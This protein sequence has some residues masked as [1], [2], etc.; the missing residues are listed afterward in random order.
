MSGLKPYLNQNFESIKQSC[1]STGALFVDPEFP[2]S[3]SSLA[4]KNG[5]KNLDKIT[6][7]R[8]KDFVRDPQ[9]IVDKVTPQDLDQG[10]IGDCWIISAM[11]GLATHQEYVD[12]VIPN[13][14]SFEDG[15]YVGMFH[16]RFWQYGEWVDVVIDDLLPVYADDNTLVYCHNNKDH[17]EM[18]G[19]LLEKAFAKLATCY[20]YLIGGN[21]NDAMID[22][23]GGCHETFD[24][25]LSDG[26]DNDGKNNVDHET[27]W[28]V[29]FS[30]HKMGS[31]MASA[32]DVME[33]ADMESEL[34]NGLVMGHAYCVLSV[35]EILS[36]GG[37]YDTLREDLNSNKNERDSIRLVKMRNPWGQKKSFTGP[38][39][40]GK[41]DWRQVSDNI[42]HKLSVDEQL[43]GEFYMNYND[44][45]V[46]FSDI[47]FVHVNMNA[48]YDSTS[49]D[50][51][52]YKWHET[53]FQGQWIP[54]KNAGGKFC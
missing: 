2:A 32:I 49:H 15:D 51:N 6:W 16:F 34:E 11:T 42:R 39:S 21:A 19:A 53:S 4:K 35:H 44:Y 46:I 50:Y 13:D 26:S 30:S 52:N 10:A 37:S 22:L 45:K 20:Q 27:L 3:R 8:P 25:D 18:F 14:Q 12:N 43:D 28:Q 31:L 36:N 48:F 47:D 5:M 24:V 7:K 41:R 40:A 38:W 54:G 9:L 1:L 17:N 29:M 23:T 33:G